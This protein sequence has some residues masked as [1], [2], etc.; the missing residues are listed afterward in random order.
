MA[1]VGK[2]TTRASGETVQQDGYYET[3]R[4]REHMASGEAVG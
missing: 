3:A 4:R 1:N 2:G